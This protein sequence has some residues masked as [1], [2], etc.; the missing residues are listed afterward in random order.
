MLIR[1]EELVRV[2]G[3]FEEARLIAVNPLLIDEVH[4]DTLPGHDGE[5]C[6]MALQNREE[7]TFVS[8]SFD[9]VLGIVQS[10]EE[11]AVEKLQVIAEIA[12]GQP[13]V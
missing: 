5:V 6:R 4:P 12:T 13:Q 8:G 3:A 10:A 1:L 7:P 11:S 9:S 2:G